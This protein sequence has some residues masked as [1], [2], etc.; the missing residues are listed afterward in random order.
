M[1]KTTFILL[2]GFIFFHSQGQ[3]QF[4]SDRTW[5]TYYGGDYTI[6]EGAVKDSEDNV[7]LSTTV[8][9]AVVGFSENY[10]TPGA[11]QTE[12][13]DDTIIGM[14][15]KFNPNGEVVWSTF[16]PGTSP[17]IAIDGANNVYLAGTAASSTGIATPGAFQTS[18]STGE[19][20]EN[21]LNGFI[22]KFNSEGE[23]QWGTYYPS[24]VF[25]FCADAAGNI[26]ITGRTPRTAGI[27]TPGTFQPDYVYPEEENG[28][29]LQNQNGFLSKFD[30]YGNRQ[31]GTYYGFSTN[32]GVAVDE[33]GSVY[34]AGRSLEEETG[35][36]ATPNCHQAEKGGAFLTKFDDTGNRL[37]ST[38]YGSSTEYTDIYDLQINKSEIYLGGITRSTSNIATAGAQQTTF[39]GGLADTFLAKFDID[40]NREWG[41]YYGGDSTDFDSY[42][43]YSGKMISFL[44]DD[45]YFTSSTESTAG[46]ATPGA[47]QE[48]YSAGGNIDN[49]I[50]KFTKYGER[51][52]GTYYGGDK[53]ESASGVIPLANNS[54]YV[55][56]T[57]GSTNNISTEGSQQPNLEGIDGV[58]FNVY[59]AYLAKFDES[60]GVDHANTL[61]VSL[62]PNPNQGKFTISQ[63]TNLGL[64]D[65][66]GR[67][68]YQQKAK[69]GE[70]TMQ[71]NAPQL[72][73]GVYFAV[74]KREH[75][76]VQTIKVIVE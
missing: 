42:F 45:V 25:T 14:L 56:G 35:F 3:A 72:T 63:A 20:G 65:M 7:Y 75:Q 22:A 41:T 68:V 18:I 39:A 28:G 44:N 43:A 10:V 4:N 54:F 61:Q 15:T 6:S 47:F 23:L 16:F 31:W 67:L 58:T 1:Y 55:Y 59:N 64:Y 2:V 40:G 8:Q 52:W 57:T 11:H 62:Y 53:I 12:C 19:N 48:S 71:V 29:T 51:V 24:Q 74:I 76:Q 13:P 5:A 21:Y 66:Q 36:Y 50:V 70:T 17:K 46:I 37:W 33:F 32:I 49:F 34:L 60:L 26:Y 38:Y 9:E 73:A 27:S 30:T 69:Q